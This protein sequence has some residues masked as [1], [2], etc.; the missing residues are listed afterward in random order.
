MSR[1]EFE[2][3]IDAFIKKDFKPRFGQLTEQF[4]AN[5]MWGHMSR[6]GTAL[7]LD[8]GNIEDI[9][10]HWTREFSAVTVNNTLLN[11]EIQSG[12]YDTLIRQAGEILER[13]HSLNSREE[14]LEFSYILNGAR[15]ETR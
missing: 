7:W 5:A 14:I 15:T 6:L 2:R 12:R 4:P 8:T 13:E 3:K 11:N 10:K 1:K 9:R